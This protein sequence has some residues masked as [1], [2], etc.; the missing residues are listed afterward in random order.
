VRRSVVT[1]ASTGLE[2]PAKWR[3]KKELPGSASNWPVPG[4]SGFLAS[5]SRANTRKEGSHGHRDNR[6]R[7]G[8]GRQ[9]SPRIP[10]FVTSTATLEYSLIAASISANWGSIRRSKK[11]A[12]C[13]GTGAFRNKPKLDDLSKKL[14]QERKVDPAMIALLRQFPKDAARWT[15]SAPRF[16][17]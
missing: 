2:T 5:H 10:V 1:G 4:R 7:Q 11:R 12:S 6:P 13:C 15:C 3:N 9:S 17:R 14:G 8:F 16:P